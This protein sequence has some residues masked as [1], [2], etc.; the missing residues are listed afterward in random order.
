LGYRIGSN[1]KF[2][3]T[4]L[5]LGRYPHLK[6]QQTREREKHLQSARESFQAAFLKRY[7]EFELKEAQKAME[8][9]EFQTLETERLVLA[10]SFESMTPMVTF[11]PLE[12][13]V[14]EQVSH[15]L[16]ISGL[17]E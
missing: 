14:E 1:P 7:R 17:Y 13:S 10:T 2:F 3:E 12:V 5:E 15:S 4:D 8:Q 11:S 16:T 9:K 6:G